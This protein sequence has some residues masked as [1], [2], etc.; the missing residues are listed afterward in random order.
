MA[1]KIRQNTTG[2]KYV[3]N[4]TKDAETLGI[5][6]AELNEILNSKGGVTA[7]ARELFKRIVP[8]NKRSVAHWNKLSNEVVLR[9]KQVI[10][11]WIIKCVCFPLNISLIFSEFLESYYGQLEVDSKK[12]HSSLVGCLRNARGKQKKAQQQIE[13]SNDN[14]NSDDQLEE[15]ADAVDADEI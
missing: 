12:M 10:R 13:A 8:E 15:I 4:L 2:Y 9:E 3:G 1:D 11:K 5:P 7:I 14:N 6:V